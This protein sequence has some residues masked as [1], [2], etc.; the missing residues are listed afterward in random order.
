MSN[1][2]YGGSATSSF[3][4]T[5]NGGNAQFAECPDP[6]QSVPG[7]RV[8][9]A[10]ESRA[11]PVLPGNHHMDTRSKDPSDVV[12]FGMD[13]LRWLNGDTISTSEWS[14]RGP[15]DTN[16]LAIKSD[17]A[18]SKTDTLATCWL[19]KGVAGTTYVLT[20]KIVTTGGRTVERSVKIR[21]EEK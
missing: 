18:P 5:I 2:I 10:A 12:D 17:P 21:C 9:V 1:Q 4:S 14:L 13:W 19:E 6:P 8:I 20:N 16:D 15:S 3:T 11:I 7:I